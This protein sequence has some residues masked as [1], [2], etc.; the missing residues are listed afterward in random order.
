MNRCQKYFFDNGLEVSVSKSAVTVFTRH[1]LPYRKIIQLNNVEMAWKNSFRYLGVILDQKLTWEDH[2]N[3]ILSK[4]E[5]SLNLLKAVTRRH[6][7]AD[8]KISLM[9]YKAYVRALIDFGSIFYGSA[10]KTRLL[11]IDCLQ[12]K[13][14]QI[15]TGALSSTPTND[16]LAETGESPL[17]LRILHL[18]EKCIV[19]NIFIQNDFLVNKINKISLDNLTNSYWVHTNS[20]PLVDAFIETSKF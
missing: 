3:S 8:P 12:H 17:S 5:K 9:F 14:L 1:R 18:A 16:L 13:A 2:I 7:G 19:K 11:K 15:I 20:P 4:V 10:T 6:R